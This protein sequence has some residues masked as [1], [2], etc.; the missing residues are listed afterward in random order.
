M[1][2]LV[3]KEISLLLEESYSFLY[4]YFSVQIQGTILLCY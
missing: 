3:A 1:E 4:N 2:I